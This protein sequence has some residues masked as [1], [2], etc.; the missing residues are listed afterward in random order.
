MK[1]A[2]ELKKRDRTSS[3]PETAGAMKPS[4]SA[5]T[6][7]SPD[8]KKLRKDETP[9][10]SD[11]IRDVWR[12]MPTLDKLAQQ[13]DLICSRMDSIEVKV[14][15]L[16]EKFEKKAD[17]EEGVQ[18]ELEEMKKELRMKASMKEMQRMNDQLNDQITD[19]VNRSKRNNIV[20]HNIPEGA[21]GATTDCIGL[22]HSILR[23]KL[24][25]ESS[26]EI[27]RAHRT[28]MVKPFTPQGNGDKGK[29]RPRPVHVK[30][31]RYRDRE[32][33][34]KKATQTR[35]LAVKDQRIFISDDIAKA[36]REQHRHLY[37][38]VKKMR[39]EG[40]FAFIPWS[41]PRVIKYKDGDKAS[42]GPLKT[43]K[44]IDI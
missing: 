8:P 36:T 3:H 26:M 44:N 31:L 21:E 25:I 28:P 20:I 39:G 16:E 12:R 32:A 43:L 27:E 37:E 30:F 35:D 7:A 34:L 11:M 22:V 33:V 17:F 9:S 18:A 40:K 24:K 6:P 19:L 2:Q 41:V 23:D 10:E 14:H 1:N 38:R 42:P 5:Q 15:D 29:Q 4:S 13:L